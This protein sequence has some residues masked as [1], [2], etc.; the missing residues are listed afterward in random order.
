MVNKIIVLCFLA[1]TFLVVVQCKEEAKT[2]Q[3]KTT[4][5]VVKS[6]VIEEKKK[7]LVGGWKAID[8]TSTIEKLATYVLTE[9][10]VES[11]IKELSNVSSQVV[12][13]KNYRFQILLEN[14]EKWEAQVYVNIQK[15]R[16]I[17]TFKQVKS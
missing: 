4:E 5:S 1:S 12:S 3:D 7:N 13:G 8:V 6:A 15:E 9:N 16:S 11:P 17:T 14:G 10:N 2:S